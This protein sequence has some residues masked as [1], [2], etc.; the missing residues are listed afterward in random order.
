MVKPEMYSYTSSTFVSEKNLWD[1]MGG[2]EISKLKCKF[3]SKQINTNLPVWTLTAKR[4]SESD[5]FII[6]IHRLLSPIFLLKL[7]WF[8]SETI[9]FMCV[10]KLV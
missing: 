2:F 1:R 8:L 4:M 3:I 9:K 7:T 5:A 6:Y 10:A